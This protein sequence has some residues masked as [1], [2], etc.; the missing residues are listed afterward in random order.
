MRVSPDV[1]ALVEMADMYVNK[2]TRQE[3]KFLHYRDAYAIPWRWVD[4]EA[5]HALLLERKDYWRVMEAWRK[6]EMEVTP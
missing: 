5:A 6:G 1:L 3:E 2:C 4:C